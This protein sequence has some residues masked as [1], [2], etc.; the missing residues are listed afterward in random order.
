MWVQALG[1]ALLSC[2]ESADRISFLEPSFPQHYPAFQS[3][4]PYY[5]H[6]N[7]LGECSAGLQKTASPRLYM[8]RTG[9]EF[10][11]YLTAPSYPVTSEF[12]DPRLAGRTPVR[13]YPGRCECAH[14]NVAICR[15]APVLGGP[16]SSASAPL[17]S[18]S[19]SSSSSFDPPPPPKPGWKDLLKSSG[20]YA[21]NHHYYSPDYPCRYP[22][23]PPA[24]PA[25]L[26][27]IITTTTKVSC[28]QQNVGKHL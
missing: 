18:S 25:A 22:G 17:S 8:G 13:A 28:L 24:S 26:Q 9:Y 2:V 21:D 20:P 15:V 1:P 19:S 27:T 14:A 12:C 7:T 6:H 11:G 4:E 16:T 10:Q 3:P 5:N 23:N